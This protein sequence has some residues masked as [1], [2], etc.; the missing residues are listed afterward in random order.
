M[1]QVLAAR[2]IIF[3]KI[4][5]KEEITNGLDTFPHL[6]DELACMRMAMQLDLEDCRHLFPQVRRSKSAE[7]RRIVAEYLT[8]INSDTKLPEAEK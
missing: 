5:A 7:A 2:S 6:Q 4:V 8:K 3:A 1:H